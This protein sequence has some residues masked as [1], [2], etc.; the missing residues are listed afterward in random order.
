MCERRCAF[1]LV[2]C[3]LLGA[4]PVVCSQRCQRYSAVFFTATRARR[5]WGAL[6]RL[7][8]YSVVSVTVLIA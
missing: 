8:R 7:M 2:R 3:V 6:Q 1:F 4:W 5:R